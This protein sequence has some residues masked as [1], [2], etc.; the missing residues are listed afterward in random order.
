MVFFSRIAS[1]MLVVDD[2]GAEPAMAVEMGW[3][4]NLG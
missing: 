3:D 4:W 2:D 1:I